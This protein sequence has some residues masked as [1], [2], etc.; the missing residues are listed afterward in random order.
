MANI[1]GLHEVL[2]NNRHLHIQV[3][4][5][6][7]GSGDERVTIGNPSL[8]SCT[9]FRVDRVHGQLEGFNAYLE[10]EGATRVPTMHML[11]DDY[12][13]LHPKQGVVNPRVANW[14]GAI[15]LVTDGLTAGEVGSISVELFKKGI[16]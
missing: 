3:D 4:I 12:F 5:E 6:G 10:W 15:N 1:I 13:D 11:N 14:T 2:N 16:P 9:D 8:H 7:D